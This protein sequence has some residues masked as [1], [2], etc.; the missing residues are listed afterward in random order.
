MISM[1]NIPFI[2][3]LS[4]F[5]SCVSA[6]K[7]NSPVAIQEGELLEE[8]FTDYISALEQNFIGEWINGSMRVWVRSY[9]QSDTS[10]MVDIN[11]DNYDLKMTVKPIATTVHA[12]GT[13]ISAFL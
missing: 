13:S 6:Q 9:N 1:R 8:E 5:Y 2:L 4:L 3:A 7:E 11:E 10:F 12:V